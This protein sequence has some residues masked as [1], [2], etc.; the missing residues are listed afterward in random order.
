MGV[1]ISAQSKNSYF[2]STECIKKKPFD[3]ITI[4]DLQKVSGVA[5]STFYR[6]FDNISDVLYWKCDTCFREVLCSFEPSK[7][8]GELELAQH[9]FSYWM[10]HSDILV[11]LIEINRQDI[12]YACH[13]K[14]AKKLEQ[15]F[16]TLPGL[17]NT[18]AKVLYVNQNR[19]NHRCTESMARRRQKRNNGRIA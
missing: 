3:Q 1:Q 11:L 8:G 10:E 16:G 4:S 9:F 5:R 12:I 14:N 7:F 17:D 15:S 13:M 18:N 19:G 6:A 2:I